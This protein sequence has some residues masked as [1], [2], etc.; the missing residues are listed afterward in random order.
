MLF[1][2]VISKLA[3][4]KEGGRETIWQLQELAAELLA[5]LHNRRPV[6]NT[7]GQKRVMLN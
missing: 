2:P 7:S 6:E 3:V 1:I 5:P 4:A